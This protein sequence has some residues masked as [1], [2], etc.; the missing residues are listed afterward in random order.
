MTSGYPLDVSEGNTE[1]LTGF[2]GVLSAIGAPLPVFA[3]RSFKGI[4]R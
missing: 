1:G 2:A 4:I 3:T